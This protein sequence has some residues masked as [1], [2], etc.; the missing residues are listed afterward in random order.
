G[1]TAVN[2]GTLVLGQSLTHCSSVSIADDATLRLAPGADKMLKT[3]SITA[4]GSARLDVGDNKAVL[5]AQA[6][7]SWNGSAY[8][9]VAGLIQ[10]GRNGNALPLWEGAGIVTTQSAAT[11]GNFTSIGV[12][13]AQQV[14]SLSR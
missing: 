14:K 5:T 12:A 1:A 6:V 8:T 2:A 11:G 9:G 7:G 13:T 3:A 4:A 10:S